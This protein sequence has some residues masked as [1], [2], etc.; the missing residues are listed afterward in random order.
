[1]EVIK[2]GTDW[3]VKVECPRLDKAIR[4]E[5]EHIR[6]CMG[7]PYAIWERPEM[8]AGFM[9][10]M[11]GVRVGSIGMA[12]S[13]DAI[14]ETLAGTERFTKKGGNLDEKL[15]ILNMIKAHIEKEA[16]R[17]SG[18]TKHETLEQLD[19]LLGFC[20]KAKAKGLDIRVWA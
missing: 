17:F 4:N 10:S 18:M 14:G 3:F 15:A 11:C 19:L 8:V 1:M 5:D 20:M 16:W 12:A 7:C 9:A 6:A 2:I 13:L